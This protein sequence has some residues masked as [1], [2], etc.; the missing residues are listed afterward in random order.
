M[1]DGIAVEAGPT[2][3][4][5]KPPQN[6]TRTTIGIKSLPLGSLVEAAAIFKITQ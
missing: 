1:K 3:K 6:H 4:I 2:D 5:L